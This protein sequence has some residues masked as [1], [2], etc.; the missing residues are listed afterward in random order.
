MSVRE[1]T[2]SDHAMAP[3]SERRQRLV[4]LVPPVVIFILVMGSIYLGFATPT[5]AAA[6]MTAFGSAYSSC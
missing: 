3:W 4:D 1:A 6:A 5:E 2:V